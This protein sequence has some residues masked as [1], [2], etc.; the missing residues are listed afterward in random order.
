MAMKSTIEFKTC[1]AGD[2]G[3]ASNA[4]LSNLSTSGSEEKNA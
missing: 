3:F 1:T 2:A 4:S